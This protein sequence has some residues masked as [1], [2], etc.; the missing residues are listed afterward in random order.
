MPLLLQERTYTTVAQLRAA[1]AHLDPTLEVQAEHPPYTG[2]QLRLG[3]KLT[4]A[5]PKIKERPD[6]ND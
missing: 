5:A 4:I 1:L 6:F 3:R 2:V